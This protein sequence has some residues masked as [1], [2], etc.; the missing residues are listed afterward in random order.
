MSQGYG[1]ILFS[2]H[3]RIEHDVTNKNLTMAV[4]ERQL[5]DSLLK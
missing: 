5:S 4:T 1:D 3:S 2:D